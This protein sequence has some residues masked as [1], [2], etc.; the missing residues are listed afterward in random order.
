MAPDWQSLRRLVRHH[1][2]TFYLG[3]LLLPKEE[4]RGAWAVYAA[5]RLGDEAVDGP[6]ASPEALE[7]WWEGIE[8]AYGARPQAD[9]EKALAWALERWPIP[10]EAFAHMREG[11][12]TDLSPVRFQRQ[13]ELMA[14]CYQVGGTVG[15]MMVAILGGGPEAEGRAILLGQAMQLTNILRDVGED[16]QRGRVYL[17]Q[18]LLARFGVEVEDLQARRP[19]PGYRA[20]M[21]YLEEQAR[22]LYQEGLKGLGLL[23]VGKGAVALAALQYQAILDK[24]RLC[25]YDNLRRR[26]SLTSWE[27]AGLLPKALRMALRGT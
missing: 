16:L 11:F 1:S 20:L 7:R 19:T 25:D 10:K 8:R 26:T 15:R 4:R 17:P 9:W 21:G 5:C 22:A 14:Y 3:S 6:G 12:L 23:R 27:R 13:E 2:L 18:A 24:L